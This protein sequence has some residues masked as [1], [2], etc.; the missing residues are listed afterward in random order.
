KGRANWKEFWLIDWPSILF[1]SASLSCLELLLKQGPVLHWRGLEVDLYATGML[2]SGAIAVRRCLTLDK[3]FV[4]LRQFWKLHFSIGCALNFVLGAGLY[5]STYLL[6]LFLGLVRGHLPF[7]IG[8]VVVV[9][10]ATQLLMAGPTAWAET[11]IDGR[12]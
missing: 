10:G 7:E 6:A 5:G 2:A 9:A 8:V 11:R 1:T 12:L 3:P 4:D